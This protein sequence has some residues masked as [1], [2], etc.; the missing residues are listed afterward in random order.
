[1][2][3]GMAVEHI[4]NDWYEPISVVADEDFTLWLER[5]SEPHLML[6]VSVFMNRV[7]AGKSGFNQ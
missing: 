7:S 1:M 3:A 4:S 2:T 5:L 6:R